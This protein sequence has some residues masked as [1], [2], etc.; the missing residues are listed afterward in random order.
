MWAID[1][2]I[3]MRA[4]LRVRVFAA[5]ALVVMAA[6]VVAGLLSR[7]A[8]LQEDRQLSAASA[9]P[10]DAT[11]IASLESA[12]AAN[13][14]DGVRR[15]LQ[16]IGSRL[17]RRLLVVSPAG[18]VVAASASTIESARVSRESDGGLSIA[19]DQHG[20]QTTVVVRGA[21]A[22][23]VHAPDGQVVGQ[24]MTLP[25]ETVAAGGPPL[26]PPWIVLT[27]ATTTAALIVT[28][29][30]AGRVLRPVTELTRAARMLRDGALDVRVRDA[31]RDE[32]GELARAFNGMAEQLELTERQKNQIIT[33]VAH[34]LRSPVSNLRCTVEA[35]QDGLLPA[36]TARIASL[37]AE[38]VLLERL[39]ADL[40]EIAVADAGALT[41]RRERVDVGEVVRQTVAGMTGLPTATIEIDD[42]ASPIE[43]DPDRLRQ[44]LRNLL[45]NARQFTP[46][47]GR[48]RVVVRR[49]G[50]RTCI[51]VHDTGQGIDAAHLPRV[52]DRFYRVEPSRDRAT[53]GAGL[54]LAI[55]RRLAAAHGGAATAS[56]AGVGRGATF[57]ICLP[58]LPSPGADPRRASSP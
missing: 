24:L 25:N 58:R 35:M 22:H 33:D 14:L 38:V 27:I 20:I 30:V 11:M 39:I 53:G 19:L 3:L 48:I 16:E 5:T 2:G 51:D 56:S 47:D 46:P 29:V 32:L 34:E 23:A 21:P 7:R 37:H 55:V 17:N 54:G 28:F 43:A 12:W 50:Q 45:D 26:L 15:E 13:G 57:T 1:S 18:A 42:S 41:L 8:T 6:T 10:L 36:D 40:Q 4:S 52:F 31:G 44:M 49:D 9:P